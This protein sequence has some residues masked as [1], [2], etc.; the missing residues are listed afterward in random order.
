[1][2][3]RSLT[4]LQR[5]A[6]FERFGGICHLCGVKVR[7]GEPWDAE[8]VIPL[9]MGGEDGGDNLKPAHRSCHAAKT[10]TDKRDL[11]KVARIRAKH[12]GAKKRS[13]FQTSRDGPFKAKIGGGIERRALAQEQK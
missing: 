11:A 13:T 8:H 2:T 10:A 1:M 12:I 7:L 9:A 5:A 6:I 4:Q 3:R